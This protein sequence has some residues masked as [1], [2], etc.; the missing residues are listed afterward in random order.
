MLQALSERTLAWHV[1][2]P[3]SILEPQEKKNE[4]ELGVVATQ[5]D[6]GLKPSQANSS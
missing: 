1:Q 4:K 6:Y 2:G 3:S 5:E